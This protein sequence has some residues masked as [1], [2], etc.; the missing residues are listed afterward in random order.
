MRKTSCTT[1]LT[2]AQASR[3]CAIPLLNKGTAFTENE[4]DALGLRGLLPPHVLYA[5]GAGRSASWRTCAACRRRSRNTS[6]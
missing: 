3:C 6:R 4:R 2:H 1:G 5:G